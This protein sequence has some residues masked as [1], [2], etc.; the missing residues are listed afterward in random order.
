MRTLRARQLSIELDEPVPTQV[1]GELMTG[2]SFQIDILPQ[3]LEV[4]VTGQA[5]VQVQ[6]QPQAQVPALAAQPQPQ[7]QPQPQVPPA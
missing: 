5:A 1:D 4:I 3:A 7:S 2:T 6:D